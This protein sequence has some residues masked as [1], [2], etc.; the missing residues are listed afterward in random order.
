MIA[1][2]AWNA[3][4]A[5]TQDSRLLAGYALLGA[6]LTPVLLSTG[7][8]HE[9]FSALLSRVDGPRRG[10][11][12]AQQAVERAFC[13]RRCHAARCSLSPGTAASGRPTACC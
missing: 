10:G 13:W 9:L 5:L 1:V 2:T 4:L 12:A 7:G 8:D 11:I 3:I 6:Y